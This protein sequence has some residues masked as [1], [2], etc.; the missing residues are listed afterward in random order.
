[1]IN[2][3]IYILFKFFLKDESTMSHLLRVNLYSK[4]IATKLKCDENFIKE[5]AKYASLH[6]IGKIGVSQKILKKPEKL[7]AQ[8]FDEIK[9]HVILGGRLIRLFGLSKIAE[10]I[11]LYHHEKWNGE[12]YC[13]GVRENDIPLE[14]RIVALA[15]VYDALRQKRCYKLEFSHERAIEIIKD[16][17]GKYFDPSIVNVFLVFNE[18]FNKIYETKDYF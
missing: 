6:D 16:E 9:K 11:A 12:G 10:N 7:T 5:V 14:A 1:M 17:S 15:D 18:E 8:E 2:K 13:L 3:I 4:L